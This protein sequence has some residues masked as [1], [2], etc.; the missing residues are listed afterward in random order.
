MHLDEKMISTDTV[1]E[2]RIFTITHDM[3]T[4]EDGSQADRD[5]LHHSGGVCVVP[6]TEDGQVYLVKQFYNPF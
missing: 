4:L 6:V 2:G 1:Y 5:V 3:V